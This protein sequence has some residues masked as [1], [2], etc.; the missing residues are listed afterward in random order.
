MAEQPIDKRE[1]YVDYA[2]YCLQLAKTAFDN[3]SRTILKEM[4]SEWLKLVEQSHV[5]DDVIDEGE[6]TS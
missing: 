3:Q 1:R 2:T 5:Y 4:A 6:A